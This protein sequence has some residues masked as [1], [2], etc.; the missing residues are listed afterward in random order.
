MY[1]AITGEN[2]CLEILSANTA[3]KPVSENYIHRI[4]EK[5]SYIDGTVGDIPNIQID[6]W[7]SEHSEAVELNETDDITFHTLSLPSSRRVWH[8]PIIALFTSSDGTIKG[9]DYKEIVFVRLDGEVWCE[10]TEVNNKTKV[11]KSETFGNWSAWK[12]RNKAGTYC[13]L[14]ISHIENTINLKVEN[15]GLIIE[16]QTT[17]PENI[18]KIYFCLTGDQCAI[19][20]I[21]INKQ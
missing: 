10:N 7:M 8:C 6:S 5:I 15:C 18:S 2:C 13:T 11:S 9:K 14:S 19:T 21:N 20:E 16:N 3:E 4:A 12:Q 1:F 17:I